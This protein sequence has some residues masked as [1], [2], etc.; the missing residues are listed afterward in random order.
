[1]MMDWA[2]LGDWQMAA[3]VSFISRQTFALDAI[4]DSRLFAPRV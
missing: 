1:M 4:E 2:R 3:S